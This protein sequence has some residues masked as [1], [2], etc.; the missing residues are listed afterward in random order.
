VDEAIARRLTC[1]A[2]AIENDK[3]RQGAMNLARRRESS[4]GISGALILASTEDGI[5]V[6]PD[7]L[8]AD[9]VLLNCP[10]GGCTGRQRCWS[11]EST[12]SPCRAR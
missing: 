3:D 4:A 7:D 6:S 11:T 9:P 12:P 10:N 2:L 5:V 8:D 1:D